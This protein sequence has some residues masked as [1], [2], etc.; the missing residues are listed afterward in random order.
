M[1][2]GQPLPR[3]HMSPAAALQRLAEKGTTF[4]TFFSHGTLEVE[5]YRPRG[6]DNQQP[7][8]KDEIYV[9][10]SGNGTFFCAGISQPF[11]TGDLLFVPASAEHRF[12]DFTSDFT[13]WVIFYGPKGGEGQSL[14][15][16]GQK[17]PR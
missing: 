10:A 7:H 4:Q 14:D 12:V 13:T 2:K 8:D 3:F 17:D 9:V 6:E 15:G 11:K 16:R 1:T 5:L